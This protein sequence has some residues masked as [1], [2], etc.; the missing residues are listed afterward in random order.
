[1]KSLIKEATEADPIQAFDS[2]LQKTENLSFLRMGDGELRFLLESQDGTRC[3]D[4]YAIASKPSLGSGVKGAAANRASDYQRI[5][6]AYENC[7]YLDLHLH[8]PFIRDRLKLLKWN[9][10][11]DGWQSKDASDSRILPRWFLTH[12]HNYVAEHKCLFCA[13]E[14][15]LQEALLQD[16]DYRQCAVKVWPENYQA[17]FLPLPNFGRYLSR[18]YND[19]RQSIASAI[20]RN[21]YDTVFIGASGL[22]K[23]LCVEIAKTY[24]VK[25]LD[26][27]SILRAMTYSATAGDATWPAN[28]NPY[29][30]SIPLSVY[31]K[32]T[33]KAYPHLKPHELIAKANA[34]LCFDLIHGKSGATVRTSASDRFD[35][36]EENQ[37]VFKE[38]YIYYLN[39]L[40][41][42][43]QGYDKVRTQVLDLHWWM[44]T[45]GLTHLIPF[46]SRVTLLLDRAKRLL[47]K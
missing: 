36:Q 39:E 27:G 30:F 47:H 35:T 26:L 10:R 15:P 31:M 4:N 17:D 19:M 23:P 43:F 33:R 16:P 22:A 45:K 40:I 5:L 12:F 46:T 20:H 3:D 41:P 1:M 29:Y 38:N 32:A 11:E 9:R 21:D 28:H 42:E 6:E 24:Q 13:G 25:A 18:D 34:Q 7:D 14:S 37:K 8:L 2:V 44:K